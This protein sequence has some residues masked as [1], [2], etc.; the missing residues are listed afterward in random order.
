MLLHEPPVAVDSEDFYVLSF[1]LTLLLIIIILLLHSNRVKHIKNRQLKERQQ[2]IETK[3][4]E[5]LAVIDKLKAKN[6]ELREEKLK[7]EEAN[8]SKEMFLSAMS[9]EIRTP[10]NAV[11]GLTNYLLEDNPKDYQ[12]ESLNALKFS[13]K[14][15]M[16]LLNDILDFSKIEA[17]K[18]EFEE[19]SFNFP[20]LLGNLE[21]AVRTKAEMKNLEFAFQL[22]EGLPTQILGDPVR[23]SQILNNLLDNAVKFTEEGSVS[24]QVKVLEKTSETV[25]LYFE[26][27][28]TGIGIEEESLTI[29]FD[30]FTQ[31]KR[32][33]TRKYGGTGLGL[34]ITRKLLEIQGSEIV[35]ESEKGKGS[36]FYFELAFGIGDNQVAYESDTDEKIYH[37]KGRKI[38]MVE[39]NK[40]NQL[41]ARKFLDR[42]EA[43]SEIAENGLE[44][45][46]MARNN[47]YDLI[48]MDIQMPEMDGYT[49]SREIRKFNETIPIIALT[50]S[51]MVN[52]KVRVYGAGMNDI[53][54]KPFDPK[55]FNHKIAKSL[56]T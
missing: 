35:V 6:M 48:L 12:L 24:L 4:T 54:V 53:L 8:R 1:L 23:L 37:F 38:L 46:E 34:A 45:V 29:I 19:V 13:A 27:S 21:N 42:W 20:E 15:L 26:I 28:D 22:D 17:D 39:D 7:S 3:N 36:R 32:E 55:E 44:G 52:V 9:H 2:V 30:A 33:I 25:K 50:A 41:V 10:M 11:V 56:E 5:I 47:A 49:A 51:A 16:V 14:N 40:V 31:E 43:T 18:L